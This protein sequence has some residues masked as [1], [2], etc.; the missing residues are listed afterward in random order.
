[1]HNPRKPAHLFP[2]PDLHFVKKKTVRIRLFLIRTGTAK[3][4]RTRD[5][6][7]N[8]Q[9]KEFKHNTILLKR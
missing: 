8:L 2:Y 6:E 4:N 9:E 7:Q 3:E 5:V 1:M